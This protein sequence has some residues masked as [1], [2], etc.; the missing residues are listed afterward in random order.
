MTAD[1]DWLAQRFEEHRDLLRAVAYR[2]LGSRAEAEDAVEGSWFAAEPLR[3]RGVANLRGWLTTVV[4]RL[5]LDALRTRSVRREEPLG[6]GVPELLDPPERGTDPE[7]EALLADSV[8]SALL[9]VLQT[10]TPAER[11][12]FVLHDLFAVPFDQVGS[13]LGRTP[14]AAK[15]L[16]G[17]ARRRVRGSSPDGAGDPVRQQEAVRAFLAASRGGDLAGLLELLDPAVVL[18]VVF[19]FT[20][21]GAASS[22]ST[23]SRRRP[24]RR[25]HARAARGVTAAATALRPGRRAGRASRPWPRPPRARW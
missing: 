25:P 10:L 13:V 14:D 20:V 4:A 2:M 21:A 6:D 18:R 23:C 12:A 16:A 1:A 17:R 24:A 9:V 8:G 7:H 5:C 19:G 3:P 22:A 15:Q 11:I